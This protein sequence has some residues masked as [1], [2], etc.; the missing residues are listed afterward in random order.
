MIQSIYRI[1]ILM[2]IGL[3]LVGLSANAEAQSVKIGV[4][5]PYSGDLAFYGISIQQATELAVKKLNANGGVMGKSIE[6]VMEDDVCDPDKAINVAQKLISAG[7]VAVLGHF[8]SGAT[9]AALPIYLTAKIPVISAASTN[10]SLTLARKYTNFLRTIP[11]D[12][13]QATLQVEYA[14]A[15]LKIKRAA[16]LHDQSAYGKELAGLVKQSL[17]EKGIEIA[18]FAEITP[19][20]KNYA[21]LVRRLKSEKINTS[22]GSAV[23][24]GGYYLDAAKIVSAARK[25]RNNAY[26]ISGNGVK[27]SAFLQLTG[28]YSLNSYVS[29]VDASQVPLAQEVIKE[30]RATYGEDPGTF[31][32]Q[33][34]AAILTL[35][36]AMEKA[37]STS[38]NEIIQSL[39]TEKL[40]TPLGTIS[41]D[42]NGD[43]VGSSFAMFQVRPTFITAE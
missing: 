38:Y 32:L 15:K 5:A 41:F 43:I 11:H 35:T 20:A 2:I 8:C 36:H 33:A 22:R 29:A 23:F 26:F 4:V 40:E 9:E 16:V 10:P 42:Q 21:T 31:S 39:K 34:Y 30:Y 6:L 7:V 19:E 14:T 13:T 28:R 17:E 27:N 24:F 3:C 1:L 12:V 37:Q 25:K 18:I